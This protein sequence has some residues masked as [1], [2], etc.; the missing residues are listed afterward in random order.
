MT[1]PEGHTDPPK[2][3]IKVL[4]RFL[5]PH[6][7]DGVLGDLLEDFDYNTNKYGHR[8]ARLKFLKTVFGILRQRN[9]KNKSHYR[10]HSNFN[11]MFKN[12]LKTSFRSFY[13]R[14][15]Y[16]LLNIL[17]L[18]IGLASFIA[19]QKY[20]E[21]EKS[22][23]QFHDGAESIQRILKFDEGNQS[24]TVGNHPD[25]GL[26][27]KSNIPG[28]ESATRFYNR[29]NG[30]LQYT[31]DGDMDLF[32]DFDLFYADNN[33]FT[34]FTFPFIKGSGINPLEQPNSIVLTESL[35]SRIF[36]DE[37][38]IGKTV[39]FKDPN[40]P[41]LPC[42][43]VGV[44]KDVPKNSHFSFDAVLS[45]NTPVRD[46]ASLD[47]LGWNAYS[48]YVKL[49]G[50]LSDEQLERVAREQY[51]ENSNLKLRSQN[52]TDIHLNSGA[53]FEVSENGDKRL[54]NYLA[55]TAVFILL[56][57]YFNYINFSTAKSLER[58]KEVGVRKVMGSRKSDLTIQFLVETFLINLVSLVLAFVLL[59]GLAP[60]IPMT[61][62]SLNLDGLFDFYGN[63][64]VYIVLAFV[65]GTIISGLYPAIMMSSFKPSVILRG[66]FSR[67]SSGKTI[68]GLLTSLQSTISVALVIITTVIYSQIN[69]M[70]NQDKGVDITDVVVIETPD[71][72]GENYRTQLDVYKNML[73]AH[74]FVQSVS[75]SSTLPGNSLNYAT[76]VRLPN[77]RV[78]ES[79]MLHTDGI[80][81][82]FVSH[83]DA[84]LLAGRTFD[85]SFGREFDNVLLNE[86][87]IRLLG[88][89]SPEEALRTKV[90]MEGDTFTVIGVIGDYNHYSLKQSVNPQ[91]FRFY[92]S[93]VPHFSVKMTANSQD[94]WTRQ[95]TLL[96]DDFHEAFGDNIFN[97]SFLEQRFNAQYDEDR[98]FGNISGF[99]SA[100]AII[101]AILGL[102]GFIAFTVSIKSKEIAIRKVLGA[103]KGNIILNIS[104]SAILL[105]LIS[106]L[107]AGGIAYYF[108][109]DW[110]NQYAAKLNLT[111]FHFLVPIVG[112]VVVVGIIITIQAMSLLSKNPVSAINTES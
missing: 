97:A 83:Y 31:R 13:R 4:K 71:I 38:P 68:R 76:P 87:S 59:I 16:F 66:K 112:L 75:T 109:G 60:I 105:N 101:I 17:G 37:D 11:A 88:I 61:N 63:E 29:N 22:F 6:I 36:G 5:S 77:Q 20:V 52:I 48:T 24:Y 9:L 86:T 89:N 46:G 108:L 93:W 80:D 84:D 111:L 95:I 91:I 62:V 53:L 72:R 98:Q 92:G 65:I 32:K 2:W 10:Q 104:R 96:E 79:I 102:L 12:Y 28:V 23:D 1:D 15:A 39:H 110:L 107:V 81:E 99:F 21:F 78:E 47:K 41:L 100:I 55:L 25:V 74:P 82:E 14:K 33:F 57:A 40:F 56:M 50:D 26:K 18:S 45:L 30:I 85:R 27:L 49:N 69:F 8:K 51:V 54:T 94:G 43:V 103:S 44:T 34:V 67:S 3:A 42:T 58:A 70:I 35:A 7:Y 19:I 90:L 106:G 64:V 73:L